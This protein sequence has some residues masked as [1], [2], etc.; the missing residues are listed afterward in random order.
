M[1][2]LV[3]VAFGLELVTGAGRALAQQRPLGVDV[4]DFQGNSVN[5]SNVQGSGI[6]FAWTK[7]TEGASGEYVSQA[8]FTIN[9]NAGKAAGV[10]M[11]AYHF[12]HPGQNPPAS[13]ASYFWSVAQPYVLADGKTLMPMLDMEVFTGLDGASSYSD[14]VNDWCVDIV[15]SAANTGVTVR[16]FIYVS[17]CNAGEFDSTVS[18]WYSDIANYGT[19]NGGNN[20]QTGTP[21]SSCSG[22]D[23][24]G[25]GVWHVWQY[26][27][28]G[29]TPG[30][31]GNCDEDVYIGSL[32]TFTNTFIATVSG[33][34]AIYY[35]DPQAN[36][37]SIP[38]TGSLTGT[39]ETSDWSSSPGGQAS[40]FAWVEGKAACFAANSGTGTP[41]FTLTMN[42]NHVVAGFFD[43]GLNNPKACNVT[44]TGAG[45]IGLASGAQAMDSKNGSDGSTAFLTIS[46]TIAGD[47][48][49]VPEGNGQIFLYG[50]N[51]YSGGTALGFSSVP[52]SG[53][54][55]FNNDSSF[56]TGGITLQSVG[57]GGALVASGA[58]A[59]NITNSVTV[60]SATT[61]N[62]VGNAAGVTFS[63]PWSLGAA[64]NIGSG[65]SASFLI[66]ISGAISGSGALTKYNPGILALSG[67]NTYT[68]ANLFEAGTVRVSADNNLGGVP[69]S[70][71]AASITLS[72]VTFNATGSF[73][74]N[75]KRGI[76]L[77]ANSTISV[78]ASQNLT[79]GGIM[80]GSGFGITKTTTGTLTLSG[81]NTYSGATAVSQGTLALASGGS[82]GASA[83]TVSSGA[84][85][86]N[87]STTTRT[88][89]GATTLNSGALAS[90][91]GTGPGTLGKISVTGNLALNN[92]AIT[93]N[94]SGSSLA[95]GTYR[96][97]DCTGT[98]SGS[99]NATPTLVGTALT[100]GLSASI[101]T[102]TG[103]A[104]HFDLVIS[105]A[106]PTFVN[107]TTGAAATYGATA[108]SLNGTVGATGPVYPAAGETIS[109][110]I[111]GNAQNTTTS[112]S[113]GDFSI[114][115]NLAG[116]PA[117][118]APYT[119]TYSYAGDSTLTAA[120]DTSTTLAL[121][122]LPAVLTGTRAFDGTNDAPANILS[123]ANKVG[124]D[125]VTVASGSGMLAG[126][127]VG[128][129]AIT[130]FG[131]LALGGA[132]AGNYTLAGASG[133]VTITSTTFSIISSSIDSTGTN[134][135]V[136]WQSTPGT[137]Y[138]V[139]GSTNANTALATWTN[140]GSPIMATGATTSAT[141]PI[142]SSLNFFS[143]ASP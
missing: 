141:N 93:V 100:A 14:W 49:A 16:P 7:A 97:M 44:I 56:G 51:T 129:E 130:S 96:L 85:L 92:N 69:G 139:I 118:G 102:T 33:S 72:N 22:D 38:F 126:A 52:F 116:V 75:S 86:A 1:G 80:A 106:T 43:G 64:L 128:T 28:V 35:W 30:I 73:T 112:D 3:A 123:V 87:T 15:S 42:A 114:N 37:G 58:A 10:Y 125:A 4:S 59:I 91:S 82:I 41:A 107:L 109:V 103:A 84:T 50:T 136:T 81:A 120:S 17:A 23:V 11:G 134:F 67:P 25:A 127:S 39:W 21:W 133:S 83:V 121:N 78:A 89:G 40:P 90:F 46:N 119:I 124:S 34:G 71:T 98:L 111:N 13:E 77:K 2:G 36:T 140:V 55:N 6:V 48:Q 45:V 47:G 79:Y 63:G 132:A 137:S 5:W 31:S 57:T 143:V 108:I 74:L 29:S 117:S 54:V 99:A 32:S 94:L 101:A 138:R 9:E 26:E 62:F 19:V 61:N 122:P 60:A 95:A 115:Y 135:I 20:A 70:V 65:S 113:T 27:S 8:S 88:I 76:T 24:W 110:A 68:G 142:N 53:I 104:G 18:Q 66:T 105:K 131:T 12:A